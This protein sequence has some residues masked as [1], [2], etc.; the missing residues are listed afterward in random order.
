MSDHDEVVPGEDEEGSGTGSAEKSAHAKVQRRAFSKLAQELSDEELGETG[1]QKMMLAEINRLESEALTLK[2]YRDRYNVAHTRS[3]VLE[4]K[5]KDSIV[6]EV[7][8]WG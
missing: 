3:A 5:A 1:T 6:N 2:D 8:Y 7:L 4:E